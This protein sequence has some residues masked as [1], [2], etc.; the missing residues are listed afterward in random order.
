[1]AARVATHRFDFIAGAGLLLCSLFLFSGC[2]AVRTV[3]VT[4]EPPDVMIQI[5]KESIGQSPVVATLDFSR[6][7]QHIVTAVKTGYFQEAR[8]LDKNSEAVERGAL[9]LVLTEDE[10]WKVT[11]TSEATN[12]W[13]RLQIDPRISEADV[14]QK[15]VDSVTNRYSSL[16]QLDNASGYMR[17]VYVFAR[18]HNQR[19]GE[20]YSV[21]TRFLCSIASKT[22]LVYKFR[23][24][25]D[26]AG[27]N[28]VWSPYPRVFKED[29]ALI[30]E[31]QN[32][33]GVK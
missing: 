25:A 9:H 16:E 32:R 7:Q 5:D 28:G 1:M 12:S 21:R 24:E 13:L 17:T 31:L 23:I 11:T 33:M 29:A 2:S 8:V 22:P 4:S 20:E 6:K 30:E 27:A 14:W 19:T 15:L 3:S 26:T 10:A 18:F